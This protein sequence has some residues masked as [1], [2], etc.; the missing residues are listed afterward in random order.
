MDIFKKGTK[1]EEKETNKGKKKEKK[2]TKKDREVNG[3][4][5]NY[6]LALLCI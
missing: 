1:T 2:E 3:K 5:I 6:F 4:E